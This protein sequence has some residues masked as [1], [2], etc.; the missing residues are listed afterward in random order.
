MLASQLEATLLIAEGMRPF[1]DLN[2][3]PSLASSLELKQLCFTYQEYA[4]A[5]PVELFL[6]IHGHVRGHYDIE[7]SCGF[8]LDPYHPLDKEF[9]ENL[10][11]F[12]VFLRRETKRYWREDFP[13]S[14]PSIG[15]F[16]LDKKVVMKATKTYLFQKIRELQL[17]GR[18][19]FGI[20]I[21]IFR[22]YKTGDPDSPVFVCQTALVKALAKSIIQSFKPG[23][24]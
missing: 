23:L 17:K 4:L 15:I 18:R 7:L 20:H 3:E 12:Q 2:K 21:E 10:A 14:P 9:G 22:D 8:E 5:A 24:A 13:L 16:P 19:I 1:V 6:E 11:I